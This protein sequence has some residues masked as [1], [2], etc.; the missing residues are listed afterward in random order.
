MGIGPPAYWALAHVLTSLLRAPA[1]S[2]SKK[3]AFTPKGRAKASAAKRKASAK[4]KSGQGRPG[5]PGVME[6]SKTKLSDLRESLPKYNR[7]ETKMG[8]QSEIM[9]KATWSALAE[10]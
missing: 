4:A 5:K 7:G 1:A 10:E 9:G 8:I 3:T 6:L 2:S